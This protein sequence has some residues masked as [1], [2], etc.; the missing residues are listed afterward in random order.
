MR[1]SGILMPISALPGSYGI[2]G[3]GAQAFA[4]VGF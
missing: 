3:L 2:G 4:F 1:A